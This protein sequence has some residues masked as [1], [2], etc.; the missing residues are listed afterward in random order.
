MDAISAQLA[1]KTK[2]LNLAQ[3][4]ADRLKSLMSGLEARLRSS[5]STNLTKV[6]EPPCHAVTLELSG[7]ATPTDL[8]PGV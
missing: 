5:D 2:E 4:E 1:E 6:K 7:P 8:K 3:V